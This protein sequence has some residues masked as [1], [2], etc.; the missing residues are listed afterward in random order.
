MLVC[1]PG[2]PCALHRSQEPLMLETK[3]INSAV[4]CI[5]F[6]EV[7]DFTRGHFC[8]LVPT[9]AEPVTLKQQNVM[10]PLSE[11]N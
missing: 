5:N 2:K 4:N 8:M 6:W 10:K 7:T 9:F 11:C 1:D 3:L